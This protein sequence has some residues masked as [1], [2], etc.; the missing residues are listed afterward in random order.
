MPAISSVTPVQVAVRAALL[1]NATL[2]PIIGSHIYDTQA[3]VS[4][5]N[6]PRI[7]LGQPTEVPWAAIN[8]DGNENTLLIHLWSKDAT[9]LGSA[10]VRAMYEG[11]KAA[12]HRIRLTLSTGRFCHGSLTLLQIMLDDDLVSMHGVARYVGTGRVG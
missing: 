9:T 7:V 11:A 6:F 2:I 4:A 12:L 5:L 8:R 1:A 3:P 10:T